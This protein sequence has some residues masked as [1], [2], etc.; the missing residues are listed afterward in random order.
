MIAS[1]GRRVGEPEAPETLTGFWEMDDQDS[2]QIVAHS[3]V[4]LRDPLGLPIEARP[5]TSV[6]ATT[7]NSLM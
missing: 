6:R 1:F 2:G 3:E 5:T 4:I 7:K